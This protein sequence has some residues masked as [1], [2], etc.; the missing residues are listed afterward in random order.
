M[1]HPAAAQ[2]VAL[3]AEIDAAMADIQRA[4]LARRCEP[5]AKLNALM[6]EADDECAGA[7]DLLAEAGVDTRLT[8]PGGAA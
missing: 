2:T 3:L 4:L 7:L 5:S 6:R 8:R 1:T